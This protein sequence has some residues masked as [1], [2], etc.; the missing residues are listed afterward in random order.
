MVKHAVP[1]LEF[2]FKR[3]STMSSSNVS[4][5]KPV[6]SKLETHSVMASTKVLR[7]LKFN[8]TLVIYLT[9]LLEPPHELFNSVLWDTSSLGSRMAQHS[10]KEATVMAMKDTSSS[11]PF[12]PTWRLIWRLSRKRFSVLL[13][14][15]SNLRMKQVCWSLLIIDTGRQIHPFPDVIRQANDT[16]MASSLPL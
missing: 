13:A 15:W 12:S 11:L 10:I 5:P 1:D 14:L 2:S 8:T 3:G 9:L 4:V 7:F 6:R 16:R